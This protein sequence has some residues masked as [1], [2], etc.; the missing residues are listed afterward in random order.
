MYLRQRYRTRIHA[1][2][3]PTH[4]APIE[5]TLRSSP[6]YL[7]FQFP[8]SFLLSSWS[9]PLFLL[10]STRFSHFLPPGLLNVS[11]VVEKGARCCSTASQQVSS[12]IFR[13]A[14]RFRL[15]NRSQRQSRHNRARTTVANFI[16]IRGFRRSFPVT[17]RD[18]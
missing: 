10:S 2:S 3:K 5:S 16:S 14:T 6:F 13:F 4:D 9:V 8:L 1:A 12:S 7:R 15:T 11:V 18:K 17:S